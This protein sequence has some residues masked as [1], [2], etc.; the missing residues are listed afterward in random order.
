MPFDSLSHLLKSIDLFRKLKTNTY[1]LNLS[2]QFVS[3]AYRLVG[4]PLESN[5]VLAECLIIESKS[6]DCE[7]FFVRETSYAFISVVFQPQDVLEALLKK[8]NEGLETKKQKFGENHWIIGRTF[9]LI[10]AILFKLGRQEESKKAFDKAI[11]VVKTY[12]GKDSPEQATYY[13]E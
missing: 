12:F 2:L 8:F 3:T 4:K 7:N 9:N 10:G 13:F 6:S 11:E 5:L 1:E